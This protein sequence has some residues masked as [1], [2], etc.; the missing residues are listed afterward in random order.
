MAG[1]LRVVEDASRGI[2]LKVGDV[3]AALEEMKRA[4]AKL[5]RAADVIGVR[6]SS[7]SLAFIRGELDSRDG[8]GIGPPMNANER[9]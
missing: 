3:A 6:R 5:C 1:A 9:E 2:D 7:R 4:G 8:G